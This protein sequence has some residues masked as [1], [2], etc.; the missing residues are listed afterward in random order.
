ML[1]RETNMKKRAQTLSTAA[2]Y[3]GLS[4]D[5]RDVDPPVSS[6][7]RTLSGYTLKNG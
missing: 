7:L 6:L 1:I 3:A 2:L 4:S 5:R